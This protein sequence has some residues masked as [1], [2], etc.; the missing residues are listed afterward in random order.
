[1]G[2]NTSNVDFDPHQDTPVEILHFI[3][4]GFVKYFWRDTV[5]RVKKSDKEILISCLSSFNVTGLGISPLP[6]HTL[7]NY[8]GSLTGRDFRAIVQAAPFIL[9]GLLPPAYI[10]LWTSLSA[11][12]TLVLLPL[13]IPHHFI[14]RFNSMR[15]LS[16]S[17]IAPVV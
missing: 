8:S 9:Q 15:Q 1:M 14:N 10:E 16:I 2:I 3:L 6:G 12:V 17:W 4:V 5:A 13:W 11:V 7:V